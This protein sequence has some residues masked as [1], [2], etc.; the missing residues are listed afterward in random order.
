MRRANKEESGMRNSGRSA[1]GGGNGV[2]PMS[3]FG[4]ILQAVFGIFM[5][6]GSLF[7]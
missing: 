2:E 7:S 5:W 1:S 3:F 4:A 6:L